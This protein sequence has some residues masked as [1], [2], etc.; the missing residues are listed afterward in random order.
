MN[1][2]FITGGLMAAALAVGLSGPAMAG[3]A[4]GSGE[5]QRVS[6]DKLEQFAEAYAD[7]RSV[8]AEYVP[9]LQQA[10]GEQEKAQLQEE[11]QQE[12]VEAIRSNGME[13]GEYQQIGRRLNNDEQLQERLKQVMQEQQGSGQGAPQQ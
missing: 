11:G 9:K 8:R 13:V 3:N 10:E 2:R 1:Y 5:Q 4:G 12:M 7:I 6:E